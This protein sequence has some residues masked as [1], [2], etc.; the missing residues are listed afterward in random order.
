MTAC[1]HPDC[2]HARDA[3]HS[4]C[5]LECPPLVTVPVDWWA[6]HRR[7]QTRGRH[8]DC[9]SF[10]PRLLAW[11]LLCVS[12]PLVRHPAR[13]GLHHVRRPYGVWEGP[14]RCN[15]MRHASTLAQARIRR[16]PPAHVHHACGRVPPPGPRP[17]RGGAPPRVMQGGTPHSDAAPAT[18]HVDAVL[19]SSMEPLRYGLPRPCRQADAPSP[20]CPCH[21]PCDC[22]HHLE[23]WRRHRRRRRR[24]RRQRR[25]RRGRGG[26]SSGWW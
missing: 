18:Q 5:R 11:F 10:A 3:P 14:T 17:S 21:T 16:R 12:T 25:R 8:T 2:C 7:C 23:W 6:Y 15:D 13:D 19:A 22:G 26:A 20:P 9:A 24:A 1:S 4:A